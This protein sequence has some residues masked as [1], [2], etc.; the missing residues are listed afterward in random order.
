MLIFCARRITDGGTTREC[1]RRRTKSP[2]V[3]RQ[4]AANQ[5]QQR[6][7]ADARWPHDC[8]DLASGHRQVDVFN[9]RRSPREK[10]MS[11]TS[12]K[13]SALWSMLMDPFT[14]HLLLNLPVMLKQWA[15]S[16]SSLQNLLPFR[17]QWCHWFYF[18]APPGQ[19]WRHNEKRNCSTI[20][21]ENRC[22][23]SNARNGGQA[24]PP[25]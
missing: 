17:D 14:T 2:A 4:L 5:A 6:G 8:R 22:C 16:V 23:S 18:S 15:Q 19:N 10:L 9:I 7:F 20:S 11:R 3:R 24:I 13:L 25:H 21:R 12:T 1:C